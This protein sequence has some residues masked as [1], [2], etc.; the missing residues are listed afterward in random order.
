MIELIEDRDTWIKINSSFR[1]SDF[2]HTY[3]YHQISKNIDDNPVLIKYTEN[4]ITIC[5]PLLLRKIKGTGFWDI[6]SVYGYAGPTSINVDD[7]FDNGQFKRELQGLLIENKVVTVFTRM[8]PFIPYQEMILHG[9]GEIVTPGKIVNIDIKKTPEEQLKQYHKRLRTYL[10]KCRRTYAIREGNSSSDLSRFIE[11]YFENMKRVDAKDKY[12]FKPEYFTKLMD[13]PAFSTLLL[14]AVSHETKEIVAG[15]LFTKKNKIVQYHLS[16]VAAEYLKLN[17]VKLL[18][19]E[20]RIRATDEG[21]QY[22]NLGGGVANKEDSLFQFKVG[23]SHDVRPFNLWRYI[24]NRDVYAE[25]VQEKH[26]GSCLH[27]PRGCQDF[28][29]CYRCDTPKIKS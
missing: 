3:D 8:N 15:A 17:P 7:S 4:D 21:Y 20:M 23:F 29:P 28:F 11:L 13:S 25:L 2:Y 9:M 1:D 16:G 22:F 6:T 19:D 24:V 26:G 5:L 14:V 12:F 18:I 27:L 10:N